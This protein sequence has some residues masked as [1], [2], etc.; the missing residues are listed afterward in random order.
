M[1]VAA[2][3]TAALVHD[4][5]VQVRA[6]LRDRQAFAAQVEDDAFGDTP[7]AELLTALRGKDVVVAFVESY[8]RSAVTDPRVGA[9]LDDGGRRLAAAGFKKNT[10]ASITIRVTPSDGGSPDNRTLTLHLGQD[11]AA[12]AAITPTADAAAARLPG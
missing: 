8:G 4:R 12:P 2:A 10:A 1:D 9:L 7:A 6:D 3:S 11:G 5:V